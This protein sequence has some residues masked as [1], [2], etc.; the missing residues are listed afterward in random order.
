L[1]TK[2]RFF[3]TK[4]KKILI[5]AGKYYC[6]DQGLRN[7][8]S[9]FEIVNRGSLLENIVLNELMIRGYDVYIGKTRSGE[10]DFVTKKDSQYMYI[11]VASKLDKES[12]KK[13][14][15]DRLLEI[16]DYFKRLVITEEQVHFT[17]KSGIETINIVEWLTKE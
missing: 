17:D 15:Y 12:T 1:F 9:D 14:E 16:N 6:V 11:Q 2:V 5:T 13:R 3:N 4:G 8:Y 7:S 10:I